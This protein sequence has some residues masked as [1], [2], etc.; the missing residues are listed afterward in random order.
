MTTLPTSSPLAGKRIIVT[1]GAGFLG[2][3]VKQRLLA[4]GV[5]EEPLYLP[6]RKDGDLTDNA[7][8]ARMYRNAFPNA[9]A[10]VILHLAAE[11]G[12]IGANRKNPGRYFFANM[13]M[14]L[15]LIEHARLDGLIE[16]GGVFVQ[17]GTI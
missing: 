4:R 9:K 7:S 8:V 12:G 10:D 16:R 1:G 11:V 17:T 14:S 13:A 2:R 15:H 3:H 5:K 6:R